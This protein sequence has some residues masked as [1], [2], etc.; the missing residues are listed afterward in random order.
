[1]RIQIIALLALV[2]RLYFARFVGIDAFWG[3]VSLTS[4]MTQEIGQVIFFRVVVLGWIVPVLPVDR[5]GA[6]FGLFRHVL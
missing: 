1:L 4:H 3:L 6:L 5:G 2:G